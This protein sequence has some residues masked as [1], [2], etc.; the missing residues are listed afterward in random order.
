MGDLN[1]RV[2]RLELAQPDYPVDVIRGAMQRIPT[3]ELRS[4]VAVLGRVVEEGG[5]E[6]AA[7][8]AV[9]HILRLCEEVKREHA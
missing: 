1:K 8:P 5:P 6:E 4:Y 3:G 2:R 9:N 7:G